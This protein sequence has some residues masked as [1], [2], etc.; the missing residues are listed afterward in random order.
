VVF[1]Y[2]ATPYSNGNLEERYK[3]ACSLCAYI[4]KKGLTVYSPIVHWHNIAKNF[5]LPKDFSFWR[6]HDLVMLSCASNMI[7]AKMPGWED[8]VGI[9][10]ELLFCEQNDIPVEFLNVDKLVEM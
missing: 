3:A 1:T 8:S 7:I 6:H 2:L 4:I 9:K 10:A 5:D